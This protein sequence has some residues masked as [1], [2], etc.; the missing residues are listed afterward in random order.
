MEIIY[1]SHFKKAFKRLD[2]NL[3]KKAWG[4]LE[5]FKK[6]QFHSQL[7]THKLEGTNYYSF[8]VTYKIRVIFQIIDKTTFLLNIGDHS[9]Y[10]EL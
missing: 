2:K 5:L 6:D 4:K 8:S 10:R 9:V 1:T 3:Q 7:K